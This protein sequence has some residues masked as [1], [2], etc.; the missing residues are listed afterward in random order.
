MLRDVS[1]FFIALAQDMSEM[2]MGD[3]MTNLPPREAFTADEY[4]VLLDTWTELA[5]YSTAQLVNM[6]HEQDTP[7][8]KVW[9]HSKQREIN[10][11]EIERFFSKL[12]LVD[13]KERIK[14]I[15][16]VEPLYRVEGVPVFSFCTA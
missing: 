7:W 5:Q 2:D 16:V 4:E 8:D 3:A 15:P 11:E 14:S 10:T 13:T 12:P 1:A 9:N 6:T